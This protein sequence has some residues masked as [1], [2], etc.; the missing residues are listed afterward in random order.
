MRAGTRAKDR[1]G[2][3]DPGH[4]ERFCR[5]IVPGVLTD[6]C[7]VDEELAARVGKDILARAESYAAFDD[8]ARNVLISPFAEE[9]A[10]YQPAGSSLDLKGAVSVVVRSSLLE[11]TH[12]HGPVEAGGI[13]GITTMAAAPLS[14]GALSPQATITGSRAPA[15][16]TPPAPAMPAGLCPILAPASPLARTWHLRGKRHS[17]GASSACPANTSATRNRRP[18]PA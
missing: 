9:V 17:H 8:T 15:S 10:G 18:K 12:S 11:E 7:H 16:R 2:E 13:E 1:Q 3:P 4:F 14:Q 6:A 5:E